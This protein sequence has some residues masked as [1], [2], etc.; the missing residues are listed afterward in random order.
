MIQFTRLR[1]NG[2]KSFSERTELEIGPGL[3]GVVGPNGCG[4]SNLVEALRWV[5][6][7]SSAKR[8]RGG[9]MEDVIFNGTEKRPKRNIAEVSLL[10]DNSTRAAPAAYNG[11]DELEIVRKIERDQGSS[12]KVNGKNVRARDVQMLFADTVTGANSPAL[13]SQGR[14]TQMINAKPLDR[15]MILEESAGISGLFA[16][17]H[18]AE[19][20]LK[21]ADANLLRLDDL[22]GGM[23]GRLSS[24]KRQA[25]QATRY[26]NL[27]TQIRQFEILIAY[28]EWKDLEARMQA[29][30]KSFEEAESIVADRLAV[31]TQLTKTQT[32]QAMDL[33]ALRK[34]EAEAAAA[35]QAQRVTLQRLEDEATHQIKLLND[36][37]EQLTQAEADQ[38]HES[39][40]LSESTQ[41]L[42]RI[43]EEQELISDE[44]KNAEVALKKREA[45]KDSLEEGVAKLE[46]R[47]NVLM[48][49]SAE[50]K[51]QQNA[52]EQRLSE[53]KRRLENLQERSSKAQ[54]ELETIRA[55][56]SDNNDNF[57]ALIQDAESQLADQNALIVKQQD[58]LEALI[59][60]IDS[61]RQALREAENKASEFN[62]EI[63]VLKRFVESKDEGKD[64]APLLNDVAPDEGF[65]KALSRAMGDSL[66]ASLDEKASSLWLKPKAPRSALPA[67]PKGAQ[68]L[69]F[70]VKAP[71]LLQATLSQIG[72]V[73]SE[74]DG[75][76]L[77]QSLEPGQSLVSKDGTYFRWDGYCVKAQAV[78]RQ[79]QLLEQKNKLKSLLKKQP[80]MEKLAAQAEELLEKLQGKQATLK[81]QNK[82]AQ[83]ER[84]EIETRLRDTRRRWDSVREEQAKRQ[85]EISRLESLIEAA[86][87]DIQELEG[88]IKDDEIQLA[89]YIENAAAAQDEP[90][91][92]VK[93]ALDDLRAEHREAVRLFDQ[94]QQQQKTREARLRAIADERV[95][96][97]NRSI[98][99]RE[100]LKT[101]E[102]RKTDL[103]EKL[104]GLQGRPADFEDKKA[105]LLDKISVLEKTRNEAADQL[106]ACENEVGETNRA[107]KEAES[108]LGEK[109]EARAHA[110]AMLSAMQEQRGQMEAAIHEKFEMRPHELPQHSA[111][112]MDQNLGDLESLRRKKEQ[113]GRDRDAIGPVNLRAEEEMS[114]LERE[115][116]G[117]LHERNDLIQAIEELRGGIQKINKEARERLLNAFEHV[118][119]H[120]QRLFV[121]LFGGGKAHLALID[122]DDPLQSGLEIFAQPPGK[123]LQSL[124]LLSGGEQTLASI[125]LIF[126]MFL[127]NPS[128]ICVLDEID[129]PLD[130]ANVDRVCD[131]LDEIAERGETRFLVITH[132]RLTMARMD[133]LYGV[134]MAEKGISQLVSV[135]LQQSFDFLDEAA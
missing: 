95:N 81:E 53:D 101:I 55:D 99:S 100:R 14:V 110:Q 135:D 70:Y 36:T 51:A 111:I 54:N 63:N 120:F 106:V 118:N 58:A 84:T 13:V 66:M 87:A 122:S 92:E 61:A 132:H 41:A 30:R 126:G 109:R 56:K 65:E 131:L 116:G 5:M 73:E 27:S 127:T 86:R 3:N 29:T 35:L 85:S 75:R 8:M 119:A 108:V 48:Q 90:L 67:L 79:A 49:A 77:W 39:Q 133:R 94:T 82:A 128:P 64:F 97:Q 80:Q 32:T 22:L 44:Q 20:R 40:M 7:E 10:M 96:L 115:V 121:Q 37:Q 129:A 130:D 24:L 69:S 113:A 104:E 31:V 50:R 102:E 16:R 38:G 62:S 2:F 103:Q 91:G 26:R 46:A 19:L 9:G 125:A 59:P 107:L 52:L 71:E 18:E 93:T 1:I 68:A 60:D 89:S 34:A 88:R 43:T 45:A 98:R 21:A 117:M 47:Y 25:R 42:E 12:Y 72:V 6:G 114:E 78:D 124:S 112:D 4:K 83:G 74:E 23:E 123:A 15:R 134:T 11:Q 76:A 28:M 57:E 17:R 33:P 105:G